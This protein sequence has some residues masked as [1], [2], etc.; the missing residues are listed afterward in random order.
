MR[1]VSKLNTRREILLTTPC[2]VFGIFL[3]LKAFLSLWVETFLCLLDSEAFKFKFVL[4]GD[5][6]VSY[7]QVDGEVEKI[8]VEGRFLLKGSLSLI[9]ASRPWKIVAIIILP[10]LELP[11]F[12]HARLLIY[13]CGHYEMFN[14]DSRPDSG[15]SSCGKKC[16]TRVDCGGLCVQLLVT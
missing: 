11:G 2:K 12:D 5:I 15:T 8:N 1:L 16:K 14:Q 7:V 9:L 3:C 6:I 10:K 13:K 4:V